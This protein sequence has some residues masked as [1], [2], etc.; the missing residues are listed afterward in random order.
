MNTYSQEKKSIINRLK[1]I[2][3]QV[4]GIQ[5]MIKEEKFCF[6]VLTQVAAVR[7]AMDKVGLIILE[8]HTRNC[9]IESLN[10]EQREEKLEELI[11]VIMRFVK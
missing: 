7:A 8:N 4:K 10:T 1:R 6:D 5:R 3:G 9:I 2:E 11:D